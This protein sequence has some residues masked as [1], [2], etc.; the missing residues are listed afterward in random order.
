MSIGNQFD[1]QTLSIVHE[2]SQAETMDDLREALQEELI[3][4]LGDSY[5]YVGID[6][7]NPESAPRLSTFDFRLSTFCFLHDRVQQAAYSLIEEEH[8]KAV[9]VK[10]GQ[11]LLSDVSETGREEKLFD[12]V[13]HLNAGRILFDHQEDR[14]RLAELNLQAGKKAKSSTAYHPALRYFTIGTELLP[15]DCWESH[16]E[17]TFA[18]YRERYECEYLTAY[19]EEAEE[20]FTLILAHA[21]TNIEKAE[22]Y[23]IRIVQYAM[24]TKNEEAIEMGRDVLKLFGMELPEHDVQIAAKKELEEIPGNLGE[25][26]IADLIHLPIMTDQNPKECIK[27]LT[28]LIS[29]AHQS[30]PDLLSFTSARMVNLALQSGTTQEVPFSYVT[31]GNTLGSGLGDYQTGYKFG[32]LGIQLSEQFNNAAQKCR[33]FTFFVNLVNHWRMPVKSNLPLARQAFQYGLESGELLYAGYA[34]FALINSRILK[35]D[36]LGGV[37]EEL[38]KAIQFVNRTKNKI[39]FYLLAGY[40]QLILN[41]QGR[42]TSTQTFNDHNF[43]EVRFLEDAKKSPTVICRFYVFKLQALYLYEQYVEALRMAREAETMR[44]YLRGLLPVVE[45]N[46]YS[47]LT[48]SALYPTS[49]EE[50]Q[51]LYRKQLQTNQTQMK[52]W[53]DN[54][55]ENFRHKYLLVEAEIARIEGRKWDAVEFCRKAIEEARKHEFIHNEALGNELMA[56]FWLDQGEEKLA[57]VY[58]L[59]AHHGYQRWGAKGKVKDLEERYPQLFTRTHPID[60]LT[61]TD[62]PPYTESYLGETL[63]LS[64]VL[65][66]SHAI[67]GEIVLEKLLRIA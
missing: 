46:F 58:M 60:T 43:D 39:A 47:S 11:L 18:L 50:E 35:G 57:R 53:A 67:S 5:K 9:H 56:K 19:F 15:E 8:K 65:K 1:L 61:K 64:T 62:T 49:N 48:L 30:H 63:D 2:K 38:E 55:P 16:Y 22:I 34:F 3:I 45:Y 66:A 33:A 26:T 27:L 20:L 52:I 54:C 51:Q 10:I 6:I 41:L 7:G 25:R 42:T 32:K 13:N 36:E 40:R 23:N 4:P 31:Y 59:E 17:L 29:P 24:I 28:N 14:I 12:I 37:F 21:R 44:T